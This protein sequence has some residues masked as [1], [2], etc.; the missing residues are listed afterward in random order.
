MA[1]FGVL[2][3]GEVGQTLATGLKDI[4]VDGVIKYFTGPN[5]SLMERLQVAAPRARFVKAFNCV[6]SAEMV[7]PKLA[8][9]PPTMFY[10]G[11]DPAA[12]A[13]VARLLERFG[14]ERADMGTATAARAIEPLAMLWCIPGFRED[15]WSHAFKLLTG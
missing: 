5:E 2:G 10:C 13:E 9:G 8:G 15:R 7:G 4:G 14:W 6:G 1:R 3:S 11:N 12:K